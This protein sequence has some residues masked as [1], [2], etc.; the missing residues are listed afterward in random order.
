MWT[1]EWVDSEGRSE[2]QDNCLE[3]TTTEDTYMTALAEKANVESRRQNPDEA[4][5]KR[6]KKRKRLEQQQEGEAAKGEAAKDEPTATEEAAPIESKDP[7][8]TS[9]TL[10]KEPQPSKEETPIPSRFFYLLKAGTSSPCKVLIPLMPNCTLTESLQDQI[11]FEYPTYYVLPY[12]PE[13]LPPGFLTE[14]QYLKVRK[15]EEEELDEALVKAEEGGVL[16][17]DGQTKTGAGTTSTGQVDAN[18]ILDMLKRD[19]TR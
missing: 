8:P 7:E 11:V 4:P 2:V 10:D 6:G 13:K 15:C 19:V 3:S 18:K 16:D 12:S 5:D 14:H 17:G 1:V 9:A